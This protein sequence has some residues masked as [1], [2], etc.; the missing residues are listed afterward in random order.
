MGPLSDRVVTVAIL[1]T[2]GVC[3][4]LVFWTVRLHPAEPPLRWRDGST[5]FHSGARPAPVTAPF[6]L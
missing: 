6:N 3:F 2:I 1:A 4:A 5:A